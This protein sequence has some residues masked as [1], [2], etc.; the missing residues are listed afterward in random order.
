MAEFFVGGVQSNAGTPSNAV[1]V[2]SPNI[3]NLMLSPPPLVPSPSRQLPIIPD[4]RITMSPT[5]FTGAYYPGR[6]PWSLPEHECRVPCR[7]GEWAPLRSLECDVQFGAGRECRLI[8]LGPRWYTAKTPAFTK[9][10][11]FPTFMPF[12]FFFI[13]VRTSL[14]VRSPTRCSCHT[15]F[16]SIKYSHPRR[17][18]LCRRGS[19]IFPCGIVWTICFIYFLLKVE[20]AVLFVVSSVGYRFDYPLLSNHILYIKKPSLTYVLVVCTALA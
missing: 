16:Q 5:L 11:I 1:A 4:P 7:H 3:A 8:R 15:G 12:S 19:K 18:H 9:A 20:V 17:S 14:D 2:I 13:T 6:Y 10:S